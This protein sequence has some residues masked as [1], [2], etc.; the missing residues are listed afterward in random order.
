[1]QKHSGCRRTKLRVKIIKRFLYVFVLPT[2]HY[3]MIITY[4]FLHCQI[5]ELQTLA[6]GVG[7]W[8]SHPSKCVPYLLPRY[9]I[10][11]TLWMT[12][13][14]IFTKQIFKIKAG[15]TD[16]Q[17]MMSLFDAECLRSSISFSKF[18]VLLCNL[19]H[20]ILIIHHNI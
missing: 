18:A 8:H 9:V 12:P 15:K 4:N 5:E 17:L 14:G 10:C 6:V 19:F 16:C 3:L 20:K 13:L 7:E 11:E 1:M 2:L